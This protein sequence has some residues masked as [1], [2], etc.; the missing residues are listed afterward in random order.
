MHENQSITMTLQNL[1]S[2]KSMAENLNAE[3][4]FFAKTE[5]CLKGK[6]LNC[7]KKIQKAKNSYV[8]FVQKYKEYGL[9]LSMNL[10]L[11][12]YQRLLI[13]KHNLPDNLSK[14]PSE[15]FFDSLFDSLLGVRNKWN[16]YIEIPESLELS[17]N[18]IDNIVEAVNCFLR[19]SPPN[20]KLHSL[21]LVQLSLYSHHVAIAYFLFLHFKSLRQKDIE[22]DTGSVF[23]ALEKLFIIY[24]LKYCKTVLAIDIFAHDLTKL[25]ISQPITKESII[26]LIDE[27]INDFKAS[28]DLNEFKTKNLHLSKCRNNDQTNLL[29]LLSAF[30]LEK[31]VEKITIKQGYERLCDDGLFKLIS[32]NC[33]DR[34]TQKDITSYCKERYDEANAFA[35]RYYPRW[36]KKSASEREAELADYMM[37]YLFNDDYG[38]KRS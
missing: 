8:S 3:D 6:D 37:N 23:I 18:D 36:L 38:K 24:S 26:K 25:I 15:A 22:Q 2:I 35:G 4:I 34:L 11:S 9:S 29:R 7:C 1:K 5:E 16:E 27:K 19:I 21:A 10:I 30:V 33:F 32:S 13:A 14:L 17:I 20:H 12:I 28:T 31:G